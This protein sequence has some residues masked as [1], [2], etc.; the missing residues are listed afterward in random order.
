[1]QIKWNGNC[2]RC[3]APLDIKL[4]TENSRELLALITYLEHYGH[5]GFTRNRSMYKFCGLKVTRVCAQ[6]YSNLKKMKKFYCSKNREIGER[7]PVLD[8]PSLTQDEIKRWFF[9]E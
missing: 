9:D 4:L 6:C 5:P 1:M 2:K 3:H 8:D 7:K